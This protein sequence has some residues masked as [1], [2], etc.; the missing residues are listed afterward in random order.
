MNGTWAPGRF[1][2]MLAS[3]GKTW[4]HGN[5]HPNGQFA[6]YSEWTGRNRVEH[7]VHFESGRHI[8]AFESVEDA[9]CAAEELLTLGGWRDLK[10]VKAIGKALIRD[11]VEAH[12]G[13]LT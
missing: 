7:L 3:T 6:R 8:G 12:G 4:K 11:V 13:E 1:F 9:E 5:V 2:C 10:V